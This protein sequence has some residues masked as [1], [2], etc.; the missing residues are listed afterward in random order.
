MCPGVSSKVTAQLVGVKKAVP[1]VDPAQLPQRPG[2]IEHGLG[3][4]GFSGVHMG[5]QAQTEPPIPLRHAI[6]PFY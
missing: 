5:H 6:P 2:E 1:V 4:R 3:Q